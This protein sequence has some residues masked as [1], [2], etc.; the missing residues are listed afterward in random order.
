MFVI[1]GT[2]GHRRRTV[3]CEMPYHETTAQ[4]NLSIGVCQSVEDTNKSNGEFTFDSISAPD[5]TVTPMKSSVEV[6]GTVKVYIEYA[7]SANSL[8]QIGDSV[9]RESFLKLKRR[10]FNRKIPMRLKCLITVQQSA[11]F[12]APSKR[13][14]TRT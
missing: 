14:A 9:V 10:S 13:D 6:G 4:K 5:F 12:A 8:L 11:D 7:P 1:G 2:G 3:F